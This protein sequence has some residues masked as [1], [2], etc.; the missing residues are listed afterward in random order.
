MK[1]PE[2]V[3]ILDNNGLTIEVKAMDISAH[4]H[5]GV[6]RRG[7]PGRDPGALEKV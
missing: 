4:R 2:F 3:F 6:T 7:K 1:N 5:P